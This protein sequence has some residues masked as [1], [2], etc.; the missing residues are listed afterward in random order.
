MDTN[1]IMMSALPPVEPCYVTF[2]TRRE[3]RRAMFNLD[4]H[5]PGGE[6]ISH[7][8]NQIAGYV[9]DAYDCGAFVPRSG[10]GRTVDLFIEECLMA[11]DQCDHTV[12]PPWLA[13][14]VF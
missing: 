1:S 6:W 8:L 13:D 12:L 14:V 3:F 10:Y 11:E 2:T 4:P 5:G 7:P 9:I